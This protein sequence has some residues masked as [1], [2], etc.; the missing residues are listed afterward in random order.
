MKTQNAV[1]QE[2]TRQINN[3]NE[4]KYIFRPYMTL[5]DGRVIWA[6]SYGKRAFRI[7]VA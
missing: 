2:V 4:T 5:K 3:P 1:A 6:R 7:P